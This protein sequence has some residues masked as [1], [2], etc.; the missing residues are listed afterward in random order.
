MKRLLALLILL[1]GMIS[2]A[3]F[4]LPAMAQA[5]EQAPV[6]FPFEGEINTDGANVRLDST[7]GA[8]VLCTMQRTEPVEVIAQL[9]DWYKIRLPKS[10]PAFVHKSLVAP[11]DGKTIRVM[12]SN[13]NV[14]MG[15]S[16]NTPILGKVGVDEVLTVV[17]DGGE[18]FRIEAPRTTYGWINKKLVHPFRTG[19]AQMKK[20][21]EAPVKKAPEAEPLGKDEVRIIGTIG[22]YGKV[23]KR[24]ATHKLTAEDGTVYLLKG[25]QQSL[26]A[27]YYRKVRITGK[28]TPQKKASLP[29]VVEAR[30][31]ELLE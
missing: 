30:Q 1:A 10:A 16:E 3:A 21:P 9:Y 14:R 6:S 17:G 5:Q 18:W 7:V 31:I 27:L 12:K 22:P 24:P 26:N 19:I 15:A 13:V 29:P 25:N 2:T 28:V 8:Q 4:P 11:V 23:I 20:A